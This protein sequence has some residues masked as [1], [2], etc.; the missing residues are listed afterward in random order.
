MENG[1]CNVTVTITPRTISSRF[2]NAMRLLNEAD[3]EL[4]CLGRDLINLTEFENGG[5]IKELACAIH[6]GFDRLSSIRILR[7]IEESENFNNGGKNNG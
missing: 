3:W 5:R 6:D 7:D 1:K 4:N 2:D